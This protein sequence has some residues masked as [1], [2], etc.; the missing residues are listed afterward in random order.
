[1]VNEMQLTVTLLGLTQ[2]LLFLLK[3]AIKMR[4]RV[5]ELHSTYD[6]SLI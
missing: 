1:M 5:S 2:K 3:L 4:L 6:L